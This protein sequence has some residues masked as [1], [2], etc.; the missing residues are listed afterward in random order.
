MRAVRDGLPASGKHQRHRALTLGLAA[1][2]GQH[3]DLREGDYPLPFGTLSI[4]FDHTALRAGGFEL[5]GFT[6]AAELHIEG[7][8][9]R[10]R[11]SGIGSPLAAD[12][13]TIRNPR[14]F[15]VARLLKVPVTDPIRLHI[16]PAA[17]ASGRFIRRPYPV[18]RR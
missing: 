13:R 3:V 15:Q 7:L 11:E 14:G 18:S 8:Q 9:N 16:S 17:M 12:L 1:A 10:Y 2:D 5:T 6:P 4:S